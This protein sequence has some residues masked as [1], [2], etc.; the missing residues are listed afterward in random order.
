MKNI[1]Y[2]IKEIFLKIL[3]FFIISGIV[4]G[5]PILV[6]FI[7]SVIMCFLGLNYKS[8]WDLV[9]YFLCFFVIEFPL[10]FA[11]SN[12]TKILFRFKLISKRITLILPII[13]NILLYILI[14]SFLDLVLK[15]IFAPIKSIIVFTLFYAILEYLFKD[16]NIS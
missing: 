13:L 2:R 4:I 1:L 14:L 7:G 5:C 12:F 16:N 10:S 3:A 9:I 11:I 15:N 8:I 6:G